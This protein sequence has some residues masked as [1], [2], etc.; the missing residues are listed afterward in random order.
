MLFILALIKPGNGSE[1]INCK[2]LP[3]ECVWKD[4]MY[5]CNTFYEPP[6]DEIFRILQ[7][8]EEMRDPITKV[9]INDSTKEVYWNDNYFVLK[10]SKK[11]S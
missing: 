6:E 8:Q 9:Q 1:L 5:T 7:I 10:V 11:W 3:P 2:E 4:E